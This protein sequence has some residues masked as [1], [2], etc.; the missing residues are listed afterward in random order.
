MRYAFAGLALFLGAEPLLEMANLPFLACSSAR[1]IQSMGF[2]PQGGLWLLTRGG[3]VYFSNGKKVRP[4]FVCVPEVS[5]VGCPY[6]TFS[7][8]RSCFP[9]HQDEDG[10]DEFEEKRIGSRG[11]GILDIGFK[12]RYLGPKY[13]AAPLC[14]WL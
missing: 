12:P 3:S 7:S 10:D 5:E 13:E 9:L 4:L 2:T 11:Y 8:P 1:R 14:S 6:A